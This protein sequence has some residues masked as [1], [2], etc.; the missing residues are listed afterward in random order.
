MVDER[1]SLLAQLIVVLDK[2]AQL[3]V[4]KMCVGNLA[5]VF[6]PSLFPHLPCAGGIRA[7]AALL[8]VGA[9]GK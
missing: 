9:T 7:A 8:S 4:T 6:A 1:Q 5:V 2:V 3:E